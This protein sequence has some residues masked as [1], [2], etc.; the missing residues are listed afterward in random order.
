MEDYD[1]ERLNV[2]ISEGKSLIGMSGE[3]FISGYD[4]WRKKML[5]A[6]SMASGGPESAKYKRIDFQSICSLNPE[7]DR[8]D[9]LRQQLNL[10]DKFTVVKRSKKEKKKT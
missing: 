10:L 7:E 1:R 8:R 5:D 3:D 2:C 9:M 4:A 6:V